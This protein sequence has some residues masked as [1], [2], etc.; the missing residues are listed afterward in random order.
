MRNP[1]K[2]EINSYH[3]VTGD[4]AWRGL[5]EH[6]PAAEGVGVREAAEGVGGGGLL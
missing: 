3:L 4:D 1:E 6:D 5:I 2:N